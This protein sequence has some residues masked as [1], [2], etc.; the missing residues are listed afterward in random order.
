MNTLWWWLWRKGFQIWSVHQVI[1]GLFY[2]FRFQAVGFV[3]QI[4]VGLGSCNFQ[5]LLRG[6][7]WSTVESP[8]FL[9][10]FLGQRPQHHRGTCDKQLPCI[11]PGFPARVDKKVWEAPVWSISRP[12]KSWG[13]LEGQTVRKDCGKPGLLRGSKG[14]AY[15]CFN[16][17]DTEAEEEEKGREEAACGTQLPPHPRLTQRWNTDSIWLAHFCCNSS[18]TVGLPTLALS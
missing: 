18:F 15:R 17:T 1:W 13:D 16:L 12:R 2:K 6:L 11:F 9:C 3:L 7:W 8:V 4:A 5:K 14:R 10:V